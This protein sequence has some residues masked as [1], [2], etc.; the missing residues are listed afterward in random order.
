MQNSS[1]FSKSYHR[2]LLERLLN[3]YKHIIQGKIL[4]IGSKYR[5]YDHLFKGEIT[6][7]DINPDLK[8]NIIYGDIIA[9][10]FEKNS[11][12][13]IICL[14]V[15]Q[16]LEPENIK[17]GFDEIH[18]VLKQN[19]NVIITLPFYCWE[20]KDNVRITA[21]YIREYLNKWNK[22]KFRIIKIGNKY[23]SLYDVLRFSKYEPNRKKLSL[24][25]VFGRYILL[26]LS[27][28]GIKLLNLE[29]KEDSFYSG[30]FLICTKK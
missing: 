8:Y 11:F 9:L 24:F 17:K 4:D 6:A 19:G 25:K 28:L 14:E 23:T 20:H 18:R 7:I 2:N 15:F 21:K 27:Y 29:Y 13:S 10:N 5:R 12:D 22:F 30:F 3:K 26:I 1:F 16:Y